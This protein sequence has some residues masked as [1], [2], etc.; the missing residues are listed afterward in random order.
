MEEP[1]CKKLS[2]NIYHID[3]LLIDAPITAQVMPSDHNYKQNYNR[4]NIFIIF[5]RQKYNLSQKQRFSCV[6]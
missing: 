2:Q 3:R 1:S 5:V 4:L 6:K